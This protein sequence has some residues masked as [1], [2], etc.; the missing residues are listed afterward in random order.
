MKGALDIVLL[1]P[2]EDGIRSLLTQGAGAERSAYMLFGRADIQMDPWS[3][4]PRTR[5]ISHAFSNLDPADLISAS[6]RH[7]T[8]QTDGFMRLLGDALTDNLVPAL[9]HTHP[10]G[11]AAF[12]EQDDQNEAILAR[13]ALM[14]GAAGLISI[15][16][17]GN[18]EVAA[19]IWMSEEKPVDITRIFHSGPRLKLD[20]DDD[21]E[22]AFLD[23]Q[24]RL[25]GEHTTQMLTKFRCGIAGG[26]A[27]GSAVLPLLM[28]L[29]IR[30]AVM[31]EKDRAEQSNLNRLHGARQGDVAAKALKA[32][33]HAR[34]VSE[35]DLGMS[36][37][38]I[39]AWAGEP[40]TWDSLKACD[41]I[42]AAR[43]ITRGDC[44]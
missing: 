26:G 11:R 20:Y 2:H 15:V 8:W 12:S 32:D 44:S 7:V 1:K 42:F 35:A 22:I 23:R 19:R 39:D 25:F 6:N 31:F 17:A 34:T 5:L 10:E 27:T 9:V 43:T 4:A 18:G 30:E 21:A 33:I 24:T 37:V 16:I 41:V 3:R 29:G 36:L 40:S 28:R 14:K 38:T 13:T